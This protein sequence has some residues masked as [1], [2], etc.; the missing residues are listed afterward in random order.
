MIAWA[1]FTAQNLDRGF[2]QFYSTGQANIMFDKPIVNSGVASA[3]SQTA[4]CNQAM[5]VSY[6]SATTNLDVSI[7]LC[8]D[9]EGQCDN[10]CP[11][12]L[13][14]QAMG[15]DLFNSEETYMDVSINLQAVSTAL[16][17][18]MGMVPLNHLVMVPGDNS[19]ISLLNTMVSQGAID[20]ATASR[21][22][23]YFGKGADKHAH[24][25][26]FFFILLNFIVYPFFDAP[27]IQLFRHSSRSHPAY[28]LVIFHTS[29]DSDISI[30][31]I[32][33]LLEI[34]TA[35]PRT[36]LCRTPTLGSPGTPSAWCVSATRWPIP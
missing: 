13:A 12:V 20:T 15:Y 11:G 22:S 16:A 35:I 4:Q 14:P 28:L 3:A 21:T 36:C 8:D 9:P 32:L 27:P 24:F 29:Y 34:H 30:Q 2:L 26:F 1:S 23:S 18:N 17:V 6:S 33:Y 25:S 5:S 7:K 19:R 31:L 10:P